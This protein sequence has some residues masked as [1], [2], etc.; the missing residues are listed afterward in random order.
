MK[1]H[2]RM[3]ESRACWW[4]SCEHKIMQKISQLKCW[5]YLLLLWP[6]EITER[7]NQQ[8]NNESLSWLCKNWLPTQNE[9]STRLIIHIV[10][11]SIFFLWQAST[12]KGLFFSFECV[13]GILVCRLWEKCLSSMWSICRSGVLPWNKLGCSNQGCWSVWLQNWKAWCIK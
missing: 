13:M 7:Q 11:C 6:L 1:Q 12:G 3:S 9:R 4:Q 10:Y 5:C 8:T 2:W